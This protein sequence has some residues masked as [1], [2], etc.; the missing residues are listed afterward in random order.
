MAT[1][2]SLL[3]WRIP[4]TEYPG[5]PQS[6]GSA[7]SWRRLSESKKI[8]IIQI[9]NVGED[10]EKREHLY[11]VGGYV[12]WYSHCGNRMRGSSNN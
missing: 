7:K 12:R 5:G 6:T 2:S 1:H 11:V 3:A 10:M 8:I 9:A 4:W